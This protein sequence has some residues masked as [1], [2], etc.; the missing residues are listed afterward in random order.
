MQHIQ[1]G[2]VEQ[3]PTSWATMTP[4]PSIEVVHYWPGTQSMPPSDTMTLIVDP[5]FTK[6][7]K[8]WTLAMYV[9]SDGEGVS[10]GDGSNAS[11][12]ASVYYF[13]ARGGRLILPRLPPYKDL[14]NIVSSLRVELDSEGTTYKVV[15]LSR[16]QWDDESHTAHM[17]VL[18]GQ[19]AVCYAHFGY[20]RQRSLEE[21]KQ[22]W[23][24]IRLYR[25]ESNTRFTGMTH[26]NV[27]TI[28]Y[29]GDL[30]RNNVIL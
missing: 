12:R 18:E 6:Y 11:T 9:R 5:T 26:Y 15:T 24:C 16:V 17:H 4:D 8:Y 20:A 3:E 2:A 29:K 28:P 19:P 30:V 21:M 27:N 14:T 23:G 25:S 13:P 22:L 10:D 7:V 1:Q